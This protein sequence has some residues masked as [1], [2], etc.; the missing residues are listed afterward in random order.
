VLHALDEHTVSQAVSAEFS[1]KLARQVDT[2]W[3][4]PKMVVRVADW[5]LRLKRRLCR[6]GAPGVAH[7]VTSLGAGLA[8]ASISSRNTERARLGL[9]LSSKYEAVRRPTSNA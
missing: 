6:Q 9:R 7:G 8:R 5:Q 4:L 1:K 2:A 3:V